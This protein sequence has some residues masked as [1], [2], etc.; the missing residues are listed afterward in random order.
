[1]P[2]LS[3]AISSRRCGGLNT[4]NRLK[5]GGART[6]ACRVG[7]PAESWRHLAK[8][9][10]EKVSTRHAESAESVLHVRSHDGI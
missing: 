2:A 9:G 10:V 7:T 6:F 8:T 1:M 4:E 3:F 5:E